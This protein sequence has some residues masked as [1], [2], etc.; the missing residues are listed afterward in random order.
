LKVDL[1]KILDY[2]KSCQCIE[3]LHGVVNHKIE[4]KSDFN[5][6]L[7]EL[8]IEG[9]IFGGNFFTTPNPFLVHVDTGK[10]EDL[11]GKKSLYNIVVPLNAQDDFNT[12][13][14]NQKYHG[15]A[16]HFYIGSAYNYYPTPVYNNIERNYN[17]VQGLEVDL[18]DPKDYAK[19]LSHLPYETVKNLSIKDI[20]QWKVGN[21]FF[22]ESQYL[23][24][25]CNFNGTKEGL[26]LLVSEL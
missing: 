4:N 14:F 10:A 11:N 8:G 21:A 1:Q 25:S 18:M 6:L 17:N 15:E 19:Y 22:F 7:D 2:R 20:V 3:K 13:I 26:T 9:K 23:H 16:T 5:W 12:I 24:S